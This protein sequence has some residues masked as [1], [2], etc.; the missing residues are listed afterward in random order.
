MHRSSSK[1]KSNGDGKVYDIDKPINAVSFMLFGIS[2][3]LPQNCLFSTFDY[4]D[5]IY[6]SYKPDF[7]FVVALSVAMVIGGILCFYLMDRVSLQV[8]MTVT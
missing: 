5:D 4:F 7:S 8:K 6:P 1:L 2:M 3:L